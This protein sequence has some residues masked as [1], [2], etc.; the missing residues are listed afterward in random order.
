M[1]P[2]PPSSFFNRWYESL[3][4]DAKASF[5]ALVS[6]GQIEFVNGGWVQNDEAT[7]DPVAMINQMSTGHEYLLKNFGTAPRIAW[8]IDPFGHSSVTPALW[9]LMGFEALVVNRIHHALKDSFK[10][11]Q[12]ME[13]LWRGAD[14]GQRTDLFTHVLHTHYSA[15][16]SVLN[17]AQARQLNVAIRWACWS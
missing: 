16:P 9:T 13:F 11:N 14:V 10:Q 8:Q 12:Q 2:S 4:R 5:K 3:S 6:R 15:P 7:P 17:R 1:C